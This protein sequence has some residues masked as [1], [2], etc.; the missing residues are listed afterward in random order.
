MGVHLGLA[1]TLQRVGDPTEIPVLKYAVSA[2]GAIPPS[3]E[4]SRVLHSQSQA[5]HLL[6][7]AYFQ[8]DS[9]NK[10]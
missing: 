1:G 2:E 5:K 3:C 9:S 10:Y 7:S 8:C 4:G 6:M